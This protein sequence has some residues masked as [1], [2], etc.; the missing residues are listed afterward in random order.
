MSTLVRQEPWQRVGL[1]QGPDIA[2][3]SG[4]IGTRLVAFDVPRPAPPR[5]PLH[6]LAVGLAHQRPWSGPDGARASGRRSRT[7]TPGGSWKT[8]L[9]TKLQR[10]NSSRPVSLCPATAALALQVNASS[11]TSPTLASPFSR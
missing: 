10:A 9:S 2:V 6:D 8:V 7:F 5:S 4:E 11:V 1:R 3:R